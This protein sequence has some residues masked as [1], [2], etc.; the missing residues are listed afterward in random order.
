MTDGRTH[1]RRTK[2]TDDYNCK[3]IEIAANE[4]DKNPKKCNIKLCVFNPGLRATYTC[5]I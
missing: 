5:F 3:C 1:T 4:L 2:K